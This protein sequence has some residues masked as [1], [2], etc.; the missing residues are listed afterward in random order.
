MVCDMQRTNPKVDRFYK[1]KAWKKCRNAY[2]QEQHYICERC[3]EVAEICH[4]K[5]Y[6][7]VDNIDDPKITLSWNNLEALCR[8]CHNKEH[9]SNDLDYYFDDEG[10]IRSKKSV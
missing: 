1:S 8:D 5:E 4:H 3:H 10:N 2:M 6:I 9:F 7:T